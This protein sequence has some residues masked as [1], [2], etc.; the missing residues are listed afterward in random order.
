MTIPIAASRPVYLLGFA[1][2]LFRIESSG[3]MHRMTQ[4]DDNALMM[5]VEVVALT[6]DSSFGARH[7]FKMSNV[8]IPATFVT[9]VRAI[10]A[11]K[12]FLKSGPKS[13]HPRKDDNP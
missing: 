6:L 8:P 1:I 5:S 7:L 12:I 2:I 11:G 13:G 9:T 10:A 4:K 3:A